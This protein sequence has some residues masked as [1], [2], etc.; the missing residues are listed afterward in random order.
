MRATECCDN[1]VIVAC[2]CGDC[3]PYPHGAEKCGNCG[4]LVLT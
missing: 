3:D 4:D 2:D 1:F